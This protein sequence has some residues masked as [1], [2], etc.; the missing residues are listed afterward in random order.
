MEVLPRLCK[1]K[2][3]SG[4]LEELLY[5]DMPREYQT[6]SGHIVLDYGKAI[7][8][9]VFEQLR[10]VRDGQLRVVFNMDLKVL[11][12]LNGFYFIFIVIKK[13]SQQ[14]HYFVVVAA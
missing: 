5:V 13:N 6:T 14:F 7:Q 9:S 11:D 3:D 2:Y 12:Y 1:I 8:E 4:T 10:V